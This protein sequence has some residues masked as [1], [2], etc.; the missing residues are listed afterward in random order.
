MHQLLLLLSHRCL[1]LE[2]QGDC[3]LSGYYMLI[4]SHLAL[5]KVL[6]QLGI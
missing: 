1:S 6:H 2:A 5:M 4:I 3:I